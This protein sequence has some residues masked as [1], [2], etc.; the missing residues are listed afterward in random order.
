MKGFIALD[1]DGTITHRLET[2]DTKV[3]E[4]LKQFSHKKWK[5]A[6]LTGRTFSFAW[7]ILRFFDF[8]YYLAVQ[9]GAVILEMPSKKILR[10]CYLNSNILLEIEDS[11]RGQKEDFIIYAGMEEGDFCYFRKSR[12]SK[13]MLDY[14]EKLQTYSTAPWV[15]WI[16]GEY[17]FP[18]EKTFPLIKC[19]GDRESCLAVFHKLK[20]NTH[21]EV[22]MIRDPIDPSLYLNMISHP[23]AN[24]G[25]AVEFLKK[26]YHPRVVIAA[27]DDKNDLP[28]F[29]VADVKIAI[30]TAPSELLEKADIIAKGAEVCGIIDALT[31][32]TKR[33]Y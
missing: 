31:F 9:N 3:S 23:N 8:P 17:K 19:F 22:S 14:F 30:E 26:M 10:K 21:L 6:L 15:D 32:A 33:L 1:I 29:M 12:F 24:K 4:A 18:E 13:K 25:R 27:G 2:V 7:K 20:R 11:Y 28:M 16:H 5:I